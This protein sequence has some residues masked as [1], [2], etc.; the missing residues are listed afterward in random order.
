MS[1]STSSATVTDR[2]GQ[3]YAEWTAAIT[4]QEVGAFRD[5]LDEHWFGTDRTGRTIDAA[6]AAEFLASAPRAARLTELHVQG[7]GAFAVARGVLRAGDEQSRFVSLW[8]DGD[9]G[10][11]C[12]TQHD[13]LVVD[14]A[15]AEKPPT[16]Q[17][18][19]HPLASHARPETIEALDRHYDDLHRAMPAQD[20]EHLDRVID[21]DWFTTDP[22]GELR[23]KSQYMDF[24]RT[25][26]APT[27]T[28]AV[29][30][31]FV[32][33][34]A[35]F[36]VS[37]CRYTLGGRFGD[38]VAPNQAVRVTG[39]WVQRGDRWLYVAQQGS[40]IP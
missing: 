13:T 5:L 7:H 10:L 29:T 11:R 37:S 22:G 15:F 17:V 27:L 33:E 31:L 40:F 1:T 4:D 32:R 6:E 19:E 26:Y 3:R 24:A 35:P 12:L 25:Y 36:A 8:H 23:D 21:D 14:S 28:F 34:S 18:E 20:L 2:I 30:E 38:G 9:H 39:I 16:T